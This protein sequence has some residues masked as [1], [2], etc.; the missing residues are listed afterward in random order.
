MNDFLLYN[1]RVYG[2]WKGQ[3]LPDFCT[4]IMIVLKLLLF[5]TLSTQ[6][7]V[8]PKPE[9][10]TEKMEKVKSLDWTLKLV[11]KIVKSFLESNIENIVKTHPRPPLSTFHYPITIKK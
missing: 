10:T 2:I 4:V 5:L 3:L 11:A 8:I 9:V 1:T 7:M 6:A